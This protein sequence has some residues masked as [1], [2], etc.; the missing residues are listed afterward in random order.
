MLFGHEQYPYSNLHDMNLD[1]ILKY[2][3]AYAT[4]VEELPETVRA[5]VERYIQEHPVPD[6]FYIYR[7]ESASDTWLIEHGLN[8]MPSV[9]ITD[10]GGNKVMGEV[11]FISRDALYIKFSAPF[12]GY[13]YLN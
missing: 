3:G 7:Q 2:V 11:H 13:A 6:C 9:Q 1:W 12:V 8:K 4:S 10:Y 5:E